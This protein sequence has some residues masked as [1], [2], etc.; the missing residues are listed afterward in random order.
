MRNPLFR[1]V[2]GSPLSALR[3]T[4]PEGES[5]FGAARHSPRRGKRFRCRAP[6]SQKGKAFSVL[7]AT[8]PERESVFGA[9]RRS[10][11]REKL[12][13]PDGKAFY[14]AR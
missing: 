4:L 10:P 13:P 9:V 11:R 3:A 14:P 6:L 12:F 7:R 2:R 8:L 5:I 1:R